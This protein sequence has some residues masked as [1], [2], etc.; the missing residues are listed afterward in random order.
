MLGPGT[1]APDF[2]LRSTVGDPITLSQ[3]K[4]EKA[5]V[6]V[7]VPFAFTGVCQGELCEIRDDLSMFSGDG[8]AQ[9]LAITCDS[10]PVQRKWA[11]EQGFTFPLLSDFWPHGDVSRSYQIFN[12]QLG[13]AMRGTFVIDQDGTIVGSF[14]S[15]ALGTARSKADYEA[16][17]AKL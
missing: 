17:L 14:E 15:G 16:A 6:L 9:V 2:T 4:G 5:V 8:R 13:C 12:D 3:Y 1:T 10:S 7:F 11:E